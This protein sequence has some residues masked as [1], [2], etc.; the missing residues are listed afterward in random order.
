MQQQREDDNKAAAIQSPNLEKMTPKYCTSVQVG[1][2]NN[3]NIILS[4]P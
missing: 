3:S 2:L 4:L 1:L